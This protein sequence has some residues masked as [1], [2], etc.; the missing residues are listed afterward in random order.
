MRRLFLLAAAASALW[1]GS[2]EARPQHNRCDSMAGSSQFLCDHYEA[3]KER[4]PKSYRG[5]VCH[6][7][8]NDNLSRSDNSWLV[9][10]CLAGGGTP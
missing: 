6:G 4:R 7:L 3:T 8:W 9:D 10:A 5:V 1:A 2:A